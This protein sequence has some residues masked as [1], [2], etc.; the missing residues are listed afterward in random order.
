MTSQSRQ[1]TSSAGESAADAKFNDH[2]LAELGTLQRARPL[3]HNPEFLAGESPMLKPFAVLPKPPNATLAGH[4]RLPF[5]PC[6]HGVSRRPGTLSRAIPRCQRRAN[7]KSRRNWLSPASD[8]KR[9]PVAQPLPRTACSPTT[10]AKS[11]NGSLSS[12]GRSAVLQG[13]SS[14]N[15]A[16][17]QQVAQEDCRRAD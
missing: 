5:Q 3:V 6:A 7:R 9:Y 12:A 15:R 14:T 10:L 4:H 2:E 8:T 13:R 11:T 16:E 1:S 17:A